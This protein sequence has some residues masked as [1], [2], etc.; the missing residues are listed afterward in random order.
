MLYWEFLHLVLLR[1][2][3]LP[4]VRLVRWRRKL[5]VVVVKQSARTPSRLGLRKYALAVLGC[6]RL[7]LFWFFFL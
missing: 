4:Q 1:R 3:R 2:S 6:I 5:F 7:N